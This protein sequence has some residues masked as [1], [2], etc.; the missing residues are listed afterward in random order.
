MNK[1]IANIRKAIKL[2]IERLQTSLD[3]LVYP[4]LLY[5]ANIKRPTAPGIINQFPTKI[6]ALS[7]NCNCAFFLSS[8]NFSF[9]VYTP[10]LF[11]FL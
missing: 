6:H 10:F 11:G 4:S 2:F 8:V 3:L 7:S 5:L 1:I 9:S